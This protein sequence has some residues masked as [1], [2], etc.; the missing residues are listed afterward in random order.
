MI[1]ERDSIAMT[2]TLHYLKGIKIADL[3]KIPQSF[4]D[5]LE[6][7]SSH[8]Y[9]CNFDYRL[10]LKDIQMSDRAKGLIALIC[11]NWWC[12]TDEQKKEFQ[13]HLDNNER[14]YQEELRKKY[15]PAE[16]FSRNNQENTIIKEEQPSVELI[17]YKEPNWFQRVW[18]KIWNLLKKKE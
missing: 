15:N 12:E 6:M 3:N 11:L 5:F 9:K 17:E 1:N 14:I 2:E 7:N 18:A 4:M 13:A 10:P 8:D 16:I